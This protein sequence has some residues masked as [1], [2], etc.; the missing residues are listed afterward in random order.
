MRYTSPSKRKHLCYSNT[1][2]ILIVTILAILGSIFGSFACAQ[3]WRLRA[4][5]LHTDKSSHS[6]ASAGE[7]S[8]LAKLSH[9]KPGP[10]RS[11]CLD[12]GYQLEWYDLIPIFSWLFLRGKCRKC[13]RPIGLLELLSELILAILFAVSYLLW[14]SELNTLLGIIQFVLW[15]VLLVVLLILFIYDLKWSLLPTSLLVTGIVISIL[16]MLCDL[17]QFSLSYFAGIALS[18]AILSGVY[19]LLYHGSKGRW[20][21]SG[22]YLLAIPLAIILGSWLPAFL[23]LFLANV[24][25][26]FVAL[27]GLVSR[28]LNSNSPV[29]F[30]P[31]LITAFIIIFFFKDS[32]VDI[33][34]PHL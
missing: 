21:G 10:D 17:N 29:P 19:F 33:L 32:L 5:Q 30:G 8:R 18:V 27:P 16:F 6:E 34:L 2:D 22:D 26:C 13:H 31:L 15:L 3:V 12:C 23:T 7:R 24:I 11:R 14:P 25:G 28:K 4:H 20:V 9:S 1:M